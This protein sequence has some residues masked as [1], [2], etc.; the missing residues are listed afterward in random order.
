[1][2]VSI[3]GP[4]VI[5]VAVRLVKGLATRAFPSPKRALILFYVHAGLDEP[6]GRGLRVRKSEKRRSRYLS[7]EGCHPVLHRGFAGQEVPYR[8]EAMVRR[9]LEESMTR[10]KGGE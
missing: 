3:A 5:G 2:L 7:M 1:M 4:N 10:G 9:R 8:K 6:S